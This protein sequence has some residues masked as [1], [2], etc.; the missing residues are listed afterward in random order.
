MKQTQKHIDRLED[1]HHPRWHCTD[2]HTDKR[3]YTTVHCYRLLSYIFYIGPLAQHLYQAARKPSMSSFKK[4]TSSPF[5]AEQ[6]QQPSWLSSSIHKSDDVMLTVVV[7]EEK[8]TEEDS[9]DGLHLPWSGDCG[10]F[11]GRGAGFEKLWLVCTVEMQYRTYVTVVKGCVATQYYFNHST[12]SSTSTITVFF[13]HWYFSKQYSLRPEI[14]VLLK[15]Q[16]AFGIWCLSII[17]S[18]VSVQ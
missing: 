16:F 3:N 18:W 11:L 15:F 10:D 9:N 8:K 7:E 17:F 13:R 6:Q 12:S 4:W 1:T 2:N 5:T 14:S